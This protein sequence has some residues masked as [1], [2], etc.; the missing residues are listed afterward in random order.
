MFIAE[1]STSIFKEY[2]ET[3]ALAAPPQS[4]KAVKDLRPHY[5]DPNKGWGHR[6]LEYGD[7]WESMYKSGKKWKFKVQRYSFESQ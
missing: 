4:K 3:V 7:Q 1:P 6:F 5:F 2:C